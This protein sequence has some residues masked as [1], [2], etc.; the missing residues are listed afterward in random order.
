MSKL[1]LK[2]G[3]YG[4]KI[5]ECIDMIQHTNVLR[6]IINDLLWLE[7]KFDDEDSTMI[8]L[9]SLFHFYD[10][11][12]STLMWDKG[13]F[14]LEEVTLACWLTTSGNYVLVKLQWV[15]AWLWRATRIMEEKGN[16]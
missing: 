16:W 7:V 15:K 4:L 9:C 3:L 12:V 13:T 11:L 8:L 5:L 10:H 1:H 2:Q 14:K 6:Q